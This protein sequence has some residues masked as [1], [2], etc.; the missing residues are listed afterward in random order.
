MSTL[1]DQLLDDLR[2]LPGWDAFTASAAP[3][4]SKENLDHSTAAVRGAI[5]ADVT[6]TV[7]ADLIRSGAR[8]SS[9]TRRRRRGRWAVAAVAGVAAAVVLIAAPTVSTPG[10][11]P[12]SVASASQF[13]THLAAT[14][15]PVSGLDD[16]YW[17]VT[18]TF[19]NPAN[20]AAGSSSGLTFTM[21]FGHAGG[22]W[23]ASGG[24][25]AGR[26]WSLARPTD[27]TA[28]FVLAADVVLSWAQVTE[29]PSDPA[30]LEAHLKSLIGPK[31]STVVASANL[32]GE[33]PLSAG[34]R[35]ALF[36]ILSHQPNV[37]IRQGIKDAIGRAGTALDFPAGSTETRT[38]LLAGDG[39]MLQ[40]TQTTNNGTLLGRETYIEAGGTNTPPG[41]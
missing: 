17:K 11:T 8:P 37:T 40:V 35:A 12:V 2:S 22:T 13:L 32:L 10:N 18:S 7:T 36:T 4:A 20:P 15:T 39:T 23:T 3:T 29:L 28:Q 31:G 38:L 24:G 16:A 34:Q 5:A 33:A 27:A 41:R 14:T 30:Q 1:D 25:P 9:A 19:A 21:W 6:R 26:A